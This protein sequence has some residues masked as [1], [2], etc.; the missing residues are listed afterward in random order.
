MWNIVNLDGLWYH[1][2]ATWA[3]QLWGISYSYFLI[4]TDRMTYPQTE[5]LMAPVSYPY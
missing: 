5:Y 3:D 4:G 1:M 2:D